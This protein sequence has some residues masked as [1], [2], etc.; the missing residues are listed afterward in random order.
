MWFIFSTPVLISHLWQLNTGHFQH[1][2]QIHAVLLVE[3]ESFLIF[4]QVG[5]GCR[6]FSHRVKKTKTFPPAPTIR[7]P[8]D[9]FNPV[10][11]FKA[12]DA[13]DS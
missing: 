2:R 12:G 5:F 8:V 11:P 7:V 3:I 9:P 4:S 13:A 10:D 6:G 1:W